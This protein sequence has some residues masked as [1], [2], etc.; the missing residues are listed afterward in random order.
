MPNTTAPVTTRSR[1][2]RHRLGA[3]AVAAGVLVAATACN[4]TMDGQTLTAVDAQEESFFSNGD[5]PYLAVIQFRVTPGVPGSTDVRFLGNLSEIAQN[6]DDGDSA[7]IPDSMALTSFPNV[8]Y[9]DLQQ[10]IGGTSPEIVGAVTVAM[11]SDAS[12]WSAINSIMGDVTAE[13]DN[14]LRTQIEPMTFLDIVNGDTA[15]T[16]LKTAAE[17]IQAAAEPSF[18]RG[19]GIFFSSF[20]DPDDVIGFKVLFNVAVAGSD[21][22]DAVDAK[23]GAGLPPSVVGG[24]L[25][26]ESF[27]VDYSGDGATYR[28]R[29]N[30]ASS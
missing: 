8:R 15:A 27:D 22:Q 26:N 30:V 13:L 10:I 24:A 16:R 20:G 5:E 17:A 29:W 6:I 12:P 11:E 14:Q 18:W 23:L 28:V 1:R 25:R 2:R 7:T 9:A 4:V 3:V 19:V 21:L